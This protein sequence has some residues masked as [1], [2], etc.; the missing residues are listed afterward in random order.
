[1]TSNKKKIV[2][3]ILKCSPN[4]V[5]FDQNKLEEI[6]E[7]ITRKD[8]RNLINNE[9]I[10]KKQKIGI[11]RFRAKKIASQKRKGRQRN[12]GSR[13]GGKNARLNQKSTWIN[14]V[15]SQRSYVQALKDAKKINVDI[16]KELYRKIKGGF[17]RSERHIRLY[18]TERGLIKK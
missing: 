13:K 15:R 18:L 6:G 4:R 17:F 1:M 10:L 9:V 16:Y 2:A 8:L 12:I 7:A 5:I 3:R 14:Q 11:S